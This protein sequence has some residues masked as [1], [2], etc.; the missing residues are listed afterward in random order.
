[1]SASQVHERLAAAAL[2]GTQRRPVVLDGAPAELAAAL[3][4]LE[5]EPPAV[6]LDAAAL[7]S[8]YRRAGI[9]PAA[10]TPPR[11]APPDPLPCVP[12]AAVRRLRE[13]LAGDGN[14]PDTEVLRQWLA[15]AAAR[16]F[17]APHAALPA[18]LD[19]ATA[20]D[21][22]PSALRD[23]VTAVLGV[24]GQWLASHRPDW[25]W[26]RPGGRFGKAPWLLAGGV[27][28]WELGDAAERLAWLAAT[29]HRDP[30]AA[31]RALAATWE[32]EGADRAAL[33]GVLADRL[34]PAD[35]D[36]LETALGDRRKDVR[37]VAT[38]LLA[39]LPA[40]RFATRMA[41]RAKAAIAPAG[42]GSGKGLAVHP[43][44]PDADPDGPRDALPS[45]GAAAAW[46]EHVLGAA[47][48]ATWTAV[49]GGPDDAVAAAAATDGEWRDVVL[50]GWT[51]AAVRQRDP[52]WARALVA[53]TGG[54]APPALL[55][56]LDDDERAAVVSWL[57]AR[58]PEPIMAGT[59]LPALLR[60]C[61][62]PWPEPLWRAV[63]R[64]L[65]T[66]A[67]QGPPWR[68]QPLLRLTGTRFP[69]GSD[70]AVRAVAGGTRDPGWRVLL[71]GAADTIA[72]RTRMLEE[73]S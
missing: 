2:F 71:T 59:S 47:P 42:K 5:G 72:I 14:G 10:A 37:T 16:G 41:A 17:R 7:V 43:P 58:A 67:A 68:A 26:A 27:Q 31:R 28:A 61:P 69:P 13:L 12:P 20:P 6:L 64:R 32:R 51:R 11:A 60:L 24:R 66:A 25:D 56:L 36:L 45:P 70:A 49:L 54:D 21:G 53:A 62:Q 63:L 4:A 22:T 1:L 38:D 73:L 30:A 40:S 65:A 46:V 50:A 52:A 34:S 19:L 23:A 39:R 9:T 8:A 29:R 57:V 48:L 44:A 15:A 3:A 33:L 55:E 35:E 18:L